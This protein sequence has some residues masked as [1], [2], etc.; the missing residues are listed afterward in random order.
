ML[1]QKIDTISSDGV[2]DGSPILSISFSIYLKTNPV[3]LLYTFKILSLLYASAR[4]RIYVPN[5]SV[6]LT[7]SFRLR[8]AEWEHA[9]LLRSA[10]FF[11]V[12]KGLWESEKRRTKSPSGYIFHSS[13][14][15]FHF[16]LFTVRFSLFS[17]FLINFCVYVCPSLTTRTKYSPAGSP[18]IEIWNVGSFVRNERSIV[19]PLQS[20]IS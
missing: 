10:P 9:A 11:R 7:V 5:V 19:I 18:A 20:W 3:D 15:T 2:G 12:R 13:L 8:Q 16:L 6:R 17:H 1:I 4:Y 14:F